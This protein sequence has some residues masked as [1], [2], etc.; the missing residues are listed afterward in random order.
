MI[1]LEHGEIVI[2]VGRVHAI[3]KAGA[4]QRALQRA[5]GA[6]A[7]LLA[8]ELRAV[9]ARCGEEFLAH[10]IVDD[11]MLQ[12]APVL[13]RDRD[14]ERREAVQEIGRAVERIDDPDV[15]AVA[16]AAALLGEKRMLAD[17]CGESSR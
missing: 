16:A 12:A 11:R 8:L 13:D 4:D 5:L 7:N 3:G 6:D 9:A 15:L 17:G 10:G 2:D 14:R 1:D